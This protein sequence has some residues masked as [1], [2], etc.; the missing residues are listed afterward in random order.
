[1]YID[2]APATFHSRAVVAPAKMLAGSATKA[3]ITGGAGDVGGDGGGVKE[4]D[5]GGD[6]GGEAGGK[7]GDGAAVPTATVTDLV[8]LPAALVA[9]RV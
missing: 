1:M 9:V 3:M 6:A 8:T 5:E 7:G 2:V 4:G